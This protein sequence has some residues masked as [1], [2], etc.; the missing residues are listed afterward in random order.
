M[1]ASIDI[2]KINAAIQE[3]MAKDPRLQQLVKAAQQAAVSGNIDAT[4]QAQEAYYAALRAD[5]I[6]IPE[7]GFN[8][9]NAEA[10]IDFGTGLARSD[11]KALEN[12]KA[13]LIGLG[14]VGGFGVA[15]P[16]LAGVWTGA[17]AGGGAGATAGG[18]G[19]AGGSTAA[20]LA[21]GAGTTGSTVPVTGE[22]APALT[23]DMTGGAVTGTVPGLVGTGSNLANDLNNGL[24]K[25][26]GSSA[27]GW[28]SLAGQIATPLVGGYLA[29]KANTDATQI[30]TQGQLEAAKIQAQSTKDALDFA[31]QGYITQQQQLAPY[32]G[33]GDAAITKLSQLTGLGTPKPYVI[34]PILQNLGS[35]ASPTSTSGLQAPQAPQP[36]TA[37]SSS[38][39]QM[40]TLKAPNGDI[41]QKPASEVQHWVSLGAQI[42]PTQAGA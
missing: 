28:L 32:V 8:Q 3:A 19:A 14:A 31:K 24:K 38:T 6:P 30:A 11:P 21:A 36:S 41:A 9:G 22:L 35:G 10:L 7:G 13:A 26:A 1:A 27:L 39:Q 23:G 33:T 40:V 15:A 17:G 42:V 5:G 2:N 18:G 16:Y 12:W 29:D 25:T 4:K 34:P 20:D 37:P